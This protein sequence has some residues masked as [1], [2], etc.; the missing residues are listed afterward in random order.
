MPPSLSQNHQNRYVSN[1][2]SNS[3]VRLNQQHQYVRHR[4]NGSRDNHI[5]SRTPSMISDPL[6]S[7][8][9]RKDRERKRLLDAYDIL[10][11]IAAGTYGKYV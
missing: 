1:L 6:G 2:H 5:Y 11:Y 9:L 4:T 7:F 10:G 3:S 8:K